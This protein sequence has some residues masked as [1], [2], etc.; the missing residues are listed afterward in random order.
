MLNAVTA[1]VASLVAESP[2][3][4]EIE[5]TLADG[6]YAMLVDGPEAAMA[7]SNEIAPSTWNFAA[8]VPK[9]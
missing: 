2:R 9:R 6:G 3:R 5:A 1:A 7:V 8:T 4:V